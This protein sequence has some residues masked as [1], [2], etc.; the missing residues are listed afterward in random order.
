MAN[1]SNN[2]LDF[3]LSQSDVTAI[4]DS[5]DTLNSRLDFL[6]GLT[7]TERISLPAIDVNNKAFTEDAINA[8]T[9]NETLLPGY[10]SVT[11]MKNDLDLFNQLEPIKVKLQQIV[12]KLNDTQM[13]AGSEAYVAA[14]MVYKLFGSAADAGVPGTDTIYDL[15][16]Q[17]FAGQ[18][19]TGKTATDPNS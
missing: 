7:V 3:T 11:A 4:N 19:G 2:R 13:L 9:S 5:I 6:V 1:L 17:R 18:G 10:I 12:E 16:K 15:L 8:A 14:L